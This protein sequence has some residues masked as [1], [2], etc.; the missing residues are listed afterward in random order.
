M[1]Y[2]RH[3]T[4]E[5]MFSLRGRA[6]AFRKEKKQKVETPESAKFY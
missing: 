4:K 3:F 5:N 6:L 1:T 2:S